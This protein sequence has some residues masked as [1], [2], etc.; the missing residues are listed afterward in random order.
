MNILE[1]VLIWLDASMKTPTSYGWFHLLFF[2]LMVITIIILAHK[3]KNSDNKT[4]KKILFICA[5]ISLIFEIY[6]QINFSFNYNETSTWWSYQWYIFPFQFCSTPMY[7]ALIA[8]LT[9]NK[10]LEYACYSFLAT[11]GLVGGI[12]VM[13]YPNT[14]FIDTIGINIQTMIHHGLQVIMGMYLLLSKRVSFSF[15]TLIKALYVFIILVGIALIL[16]ILTYYINIDGGLTLF[17]ISPFH[18][19][20]LVILC[21]IYEKVPYFVF[22]IIYIG[23]FTLGSS[24]VLLISKLIYKRKNVKK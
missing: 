24:I 9:K 21:D 10:K 13:I 14:V 8:A 16:N 5:L 23:A 1:K 4:T 15:K 2:S 17:Y 19:S 3:Y 7:I 22:L 11:F 20:S 6:K 18:R 12:S